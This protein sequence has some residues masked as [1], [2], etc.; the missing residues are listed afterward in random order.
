MPP[1]LLKSMPPSIGEI[2]GRVTTR[3]DEQEPG[4]SSKRQDDHM[5]MQTSEINSTK[6]TISR[7]HG[8]SNEDLYLPAS[9]VETQFG[10]LSGNRPNA[11]GISVQ[12]NEHT[13]QRD[14]ERTGTG[15][16]APGSF[17]RSFDAAHPL[18]APTLASDSVLPA[19]PVNHR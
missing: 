19:P 13:L 2:A 4:D 17:M 6:R 12:S 7:V 10:M 15:S 8:E 16:L 11:I 14:N 9:T 18:A 1:H 5:I 3:R